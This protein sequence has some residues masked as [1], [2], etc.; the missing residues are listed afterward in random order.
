MNLLTL[1]ARFRTECLLWFSK[2][3]CVTIFAWCNPEW[4]QAVPASGPDKALMA[5]TVKLIKFWMTESCFLESYLSHYKLSSDEVVYCYKFSMFHLHVGA[6]RKCR[7]HFWAALNW[8]L[9]L[10]IRL[11]DCNHILGYCHLSCLLYV[12]I[13]CWWIQFERLGRGHDTLL[14]NSDGVSPPQ[15]I[16]TV[17]MNT[18]P[19]RWLCILSLLIVIQSC[20]SLYLF[21]MRR[22]H[23]TSG[24]TWVKKTRQSVM[25]QV[26]MDGLRIALKFYQ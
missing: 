9:I 7:Q 26:E 21:D 23:Q 13:I 20:A 10:N 22:C 17:F 18:K 19:F 11:L 15:S 6:E 1:I 8:R 24:V 25:T 14:D 12:S 3:W 5:G 4:K 2:Q 16:P